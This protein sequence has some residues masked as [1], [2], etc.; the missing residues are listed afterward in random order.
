MFNSSAFL[1]QERGFDKSASENLSFERDAHLSLLAF[2]RKQGNLF[3]QK[4]KTLYFSFGCKKILIFR[5]VLLE[6]G[7]ILDIFTKKY[8]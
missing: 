4:K 3:D 2:S 8:H 1:G 5:I 6:G 7:G